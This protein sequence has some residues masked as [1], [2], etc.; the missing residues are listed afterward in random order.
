MQYV[1]VQRRY[2]L[3]IVTAKATKAQSLLQC[4]DSLQME[5]EVCM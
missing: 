3:I 5:G 1:V 4:L 2:R